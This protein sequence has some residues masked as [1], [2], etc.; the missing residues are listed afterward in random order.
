M[1]E[2]LEFL[3]YLLLVGLSPLTKGVVQKSRPWL[4]L[5][6]TL[7]LPQF[8]YWLT[9]QPLHGFWTRPSRMETKSQRQHLSKTTSQIVKIRIVA[10]ESPSVPAEYKQLLHIPAASR[11]LAS[12]ALI[13]LHV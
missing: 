5:A 12:N 7:M 1:L 10:M 3:V 8:H 13:A 2:D 4:A 6:P 9:A 11:G